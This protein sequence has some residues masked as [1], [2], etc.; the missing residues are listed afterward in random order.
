MR[1]HQAAVE[2][3]P[4][5]FG[6]FDQRVYGK[7]INITLPPKLVKKEIKNSLGCDKVMARLLMYPQF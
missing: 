2:Q 3:V 1:L 4:A 6:P 7:K 5:V